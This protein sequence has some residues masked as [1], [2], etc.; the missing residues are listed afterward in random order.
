[1]Q[2]HKVTKKKRRLN[3]TFM[4]CKHVDIAQVAKQEKGVKKKNKRKY[5]TPGPS[6]WSR[7][8][9]FRL[10][11]QRSGFDSQR[12]QIFWVWNGV[13]SAS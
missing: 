8:Q 2:S 13:H 7:D 1:M 4:G 3:Q 11:I 9:S 10:Q 6:L 12:Y 5:T